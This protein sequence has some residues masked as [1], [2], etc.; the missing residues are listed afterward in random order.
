MQDLSRITPA[1]LDVLE[2]LVSAKH[3]L[4]GFALAK[5]AHRPTGSV[6]VILNRLEEA[7][8][9]DSSWEDANVENEGRPRRRFYRLTPDGLAASRETLAARRKTNFVKDLDLRPAFRLGW[10]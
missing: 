2:V 4:H 1:I 7:G 6:Y 9:V 10:R 3:D 5:T 8:W